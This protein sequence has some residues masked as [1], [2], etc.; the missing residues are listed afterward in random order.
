MKRLSLYRHILLVRYGRVYG[1]ARRCTATRRKMLPD[2]VLF[3]VDVSNSPSFEGAAVL[4]F[5]ENSDHNFAGEL[6]QASG[7]HH[8]ALSVVATDRLKDSGYLR[9]KL[10]RDSHTAF[11]NRGA[12]TRREA[13]RLR[14]VS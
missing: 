14:P 6:K 9:A 10:L 1:E 7:R 11:H 8:L 3:P 13:A 4:A 12:R 2:T 5:I